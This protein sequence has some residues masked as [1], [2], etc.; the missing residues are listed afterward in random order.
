MKCIMRELDL[1]TLI[2]LY[3]MIDYQ[4]FLIRVRIPVRRIEINVDQQQP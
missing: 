4:R 2:Y 1:I 3:T